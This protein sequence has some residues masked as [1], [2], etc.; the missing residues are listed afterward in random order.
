[1]RFVR[2]STWRSEDK[3]GKRISK[4]PT[5][6]EFVDLMAKFI[7]DKAANR[8][9]SEYLGDREIDEKGSLSEYEIPNL[10]R[11]TEKT[12]AASVGAPAA[13]I[14]IENYLAAR[15]SKMEDVFNIFGTVSLSRAASR[16]QLSVLYDVANL[17]NSGKTLDSIL[18]SVLDLLYRQFRFDLCAIRI[19]DEEANLLR[20][21]SYKG[22]D[23]DFLSHADREINLETC[24]GHTFIN[25]KV[26][27]AN[28]SDCANMPSSVAIVRELKIKSFA[29]APITVEGQPI[30]VLSSYSR[31][32]K[33]IYTEEFIE[34]YKNI[35]AQIGIAYRNSIQTVQLIEASEQQKQLKIAEDIQLDLLP[36]KMPEVDGLDIAGICVPA[37]QVGGDYYDFI[38][39]PHEL[40]IVIADVS[41]HNIGAALLMAS[42]RT[43][44]RAHSEQMFPPQTTLGTLNGFLYQDLSSSE[45]F[46]TMFYLRYELQK[47]NLIYA[48]AGHNKPLVYRPSTDS[49]ELLDAEGLILG[50]LPEVDFEQKEIAVDSGDILVMYTD[51][52]VEAQNQYEELFG[53]QRFQDLVRDHHKKSSNEIIDVTLDEIRIF[54]GRRHFNDDV[55]MVVIKTL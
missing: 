41:G 9:I 30:G 15:G 20:V 49:F 47:N 48:S 24:I 34:L 39:S 17:I 45:L 55:T 16:E 6:I 35:A 4:A 2:A 11:F 23:S 19:V 7:G 43:F 28:D 29:H 31:F 44:I 25:N 8:A 18:D 46:I 38:T 14:I 40:D 5:V 32:A 12:M 26:V 3:E 1:M 21:R 51:G 42:A 50:I 27:L 33:G 54:Q 37:K 13:R 22:L 53:M 10:K 36:K 52:I